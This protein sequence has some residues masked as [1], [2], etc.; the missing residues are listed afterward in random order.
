MMK[1][2]IISVICAVLAIIGLSYGIYQKLEMTK[3]YNSEVTYNKF[4]N[5]S[6]RMIEALY[7]Y[8]QSDFKNRPQKAKVLMSDD[9]FK[10]LFPNPDGPQ[11]YDSL[12]VSHIEDAQIQHQSVLR[13]EIKGFY[14]IK[15]RASYDGHKFNHAT[16]Y[17]SVTYNTKTNKFTKVELKDNMVI[18]TE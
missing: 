4:D 2:K 7:S 16:A 11:G 17:I 8:S 18:S 6:H 9:G 5:N 14:M 15:Y 12:V 1:F 13:D 10:K 3:T